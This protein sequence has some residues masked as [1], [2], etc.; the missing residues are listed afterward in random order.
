MDWSDFLCCRL[1]MCAQQPLVLP[2]YPRGALLTRLRFKCGV[3]TYHR[4]FQAAPSQPAQPPPPSSTSSATSPA[5]TQPTNG[6]GLNALFKSAGK[7]YFGTA[8]DTN[9]FNDAAYMAVLNNAN[10]FGQLTPA[11]SMKWV[12]TTLLYRYYKGV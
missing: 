7:L 8:T 4:N 5:P 11:N 9:E 10:E 1:D 3:L 12:I 6:S 2:V